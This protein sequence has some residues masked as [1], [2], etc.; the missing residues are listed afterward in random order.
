MIKYND[1]DIRNA[2]YFIWKNNGCPANTHDQ[3]WLAA[4]NQ[5]NAM[6]TLKNASKKIASAKAVVAKKSATKAAS[7]KSASLKTIVLKPA[8]LKKSTKKTTTKKSK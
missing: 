4:I 7:L 6:S 2:A 8:S 5:L 1:N 3:D